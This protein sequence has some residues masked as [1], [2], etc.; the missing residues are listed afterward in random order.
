MIENYNT[1]DCDSVAIIPRIILW[2][3]LIIITVN[4]YKD[5]NTVE[6]C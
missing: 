1:V 2:P 6:L 3:S 5:T 4:A